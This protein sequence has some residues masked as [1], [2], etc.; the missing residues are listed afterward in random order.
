MIEPLDLAIERAKIYNWSGYQLLRLLADSDLDPETIYKQAISEYQHATTECA[1]WY[2]PF[3]NLADVTSYLGE[4]EHSDARQIEALRLYEQ[5]LQLARNRAGYLTVEDYKELHESNV[6]E[7]RLSIA[8]TRILLLG[9]QAVEQGLSDVSALNTKASREWDP[10]LETNADV[11]YTAACFYV[12]ASESSANYE[13]LR[14]DAIRS[15]A[16][17][18]YL[19]PELVSE[20]KGDPD[21]A[22]IARELQ[23][24]QRVDWT[25]LA[26][27]DPNRRETV[28]QI[29]ELLVGPGTA[30]R[31]DW[32]WDLFKF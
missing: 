32:I 30:S 4:R 13:N 24:L 7:L 20:T 17:A 19:D 11:L 8:I 16:Y 5:A 2:L 18:F 12:R 31:P 25:N 14:R 22:S 21:L 9:E 23:A 27:R 3:E 6:R 15:L 26:R 1:L 10:E 28:E 29:A